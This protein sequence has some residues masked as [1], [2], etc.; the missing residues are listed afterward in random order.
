MRAAV[1]QAVAVLG[2]AATGMP[3]TAQAAAYGLS[4]YVYTEVTTFPAGDIKRG[5]VWLDGDPLAASLQAV[6]RTAQLSLDSVAT[7]RFLGQI[8]LLKVYAGATYPKNGDGLATAT[9]QGSFYDEIQVKGA[10]LAVGTPVSY[11]LDFSISGS[12][13]GV[14]PDPTFGAFAAASMSLQDYVTGKS[15]FMNWDNRKNSTG[16]YSLTLNTAV[17]HPLLINAV[18]QVGARVQ[19]NSLNARFAEADFYHSAV[20]TLT[21]SVTGLNVVGLS[22]HDFTATAVPEPSSWALMALGLTAVALRR[23]AATRRG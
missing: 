2:L 7:G 20:Y 11:R 21:P 9:A 3:G 1:L 23:R 18:L 12:V 22:G 4:G 15:V 17:G 10:G 5:D 16:V 14:Q 13:L 6:D 19:G 8:G